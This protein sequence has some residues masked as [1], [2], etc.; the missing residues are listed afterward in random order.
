MFAFEQ[1][2][3]LSQLLFLGKKRMR[4]NK[5]IFKNNTKNITENI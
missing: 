1:L 2:Q 4:R 3:T 5:W